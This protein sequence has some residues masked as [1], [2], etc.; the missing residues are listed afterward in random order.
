MLFCNRY[1][2]GMLKIARPARCSFIHV[3]DLQSVY[4]HCL[5]ELGMHKNEFSRPSLSYILVVLIVLV[6]SFL[7]KSYNLTV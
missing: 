7:T 6:F 1:E 2:S 5:I 3:P 4:R